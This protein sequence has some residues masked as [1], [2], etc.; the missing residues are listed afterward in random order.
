MKLNTIVSIIGAFCYWCAII[1]A[2]WCG[3]HYG[4]THAPHCE[5][6]G[7]SAWVGTK[8]VVIWDGQKWREVE[9]E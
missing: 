8:A 4:R 1:A 3:I 9:R 6:N 2:C 7:N 5:M